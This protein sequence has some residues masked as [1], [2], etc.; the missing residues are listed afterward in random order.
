MT[1]STS[2]AG[3]VHPAVSGPAS[4]PATG[5]LRVR[6]L[7]AEATASYLARLAHAYRLTLPHLLDGLDVHL[8]PGPEKAAPAAE[9]HLN[10][11][12]QQRLCVFTH[13][14]RPHLARALPRL[15]QPGPLHTTGP[16]PPTAHW[17]PLVPAVQPLRVCTACVSHRS[18]GTHT[19]AW[20]Y[21][22][23]APRLTI[24]T[25]H[26][27]TGSDP[28]HTAPL[29]IRP[30]PELTHTHQQQARTTIPATELTWATTITTRWYDHHQHLAQR[31]HTRLARLTTANPHTHHPTA[32]PA[33]TCRS[34]VTYPETLTLARALTRI[35]PHGLARTDHTAFLHHLAT[36]LELPRLAPA[37]HD[38]LFTRLN[39]R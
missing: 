13:I 15:T 31:W 9:L 22:P 38:P 23:S 32:S 11:T 3:T 12:A 4:P 27:Q 16:G 14:P 18:R 33:L 30:L 34:L 39:T 28:R 24:C 8:A 1:A 5:A 19:T 21:P 17:Q 2:P 26:Q 37:T 7:P 25:H 6:P 29:D 35:P 20:A 10:P 36:R